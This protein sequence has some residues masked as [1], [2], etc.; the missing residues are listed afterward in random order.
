MNPDQ[1]AELKNNEVVRK[2]LAKFMAHFCFRNSS[3]E[4]LHN[5]ISDHEMK[6]LMIDVVNR[7]YLFISIM[8]NSQASN[9]IIDLLKHEDHLP[10]DWKHWDDPELPDELLKNAKR[11]LDLL[12]NRRQ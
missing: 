2:R 9:E 5:R 4:N 3:L 11:A 12:K 1:L 8:F 6:A 7:S 10:S